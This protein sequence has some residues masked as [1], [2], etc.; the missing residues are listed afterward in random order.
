MI[1]YNMQVTLAMC[2]YSA[3][4]VCAL[5][6]VLLLATVR[7]T[8]RTRRR[9]VASKKHGVALCFTILAADLAECEARSIY[10]ICKMKWFVY[11]FGPKRAVLT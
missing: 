9:G 10:T 4:S 2:L 3:L 1:G 11:L 7:A 8:C 5:R 6:V